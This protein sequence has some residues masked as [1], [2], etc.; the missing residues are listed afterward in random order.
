MSVTLLEKPSVN[1]LEQLLHQ[2]SFDAE[3]RSELLENP[4]AFGVPAD[5]ELVVPTSVEKQDESLFEL[6]DDA[7]GELNIVAECK[8]T[9]S[10]GLTYVCD[11]Y[12]KGW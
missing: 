4:A 6:F 3:F 2:A 11:G 9:C 7:L 8:T 1:Y 10:W 12:T 5:I